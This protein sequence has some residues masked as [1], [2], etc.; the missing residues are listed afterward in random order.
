MNHLVLLTSGVGGGGG[1][2]G[3]VGEIGHSSSSGNQDVVSTYVAQNVF[4]SDF[5]FY[6]VACRRVECEQRR[7]LSLVFQA[8]EI[9]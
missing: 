7:S 1:G 2:G 5:L 6:V 8:T 9:C 3:G 4:I